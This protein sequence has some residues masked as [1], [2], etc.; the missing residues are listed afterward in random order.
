MKKLSILIT[1]LLITLTASAQ[2]SNSSQIPE[3]SKDTKLIIIDEDNSVLTDSEFNDKLGKVSDL[4]GG[5]VVIVETYCQVYDGFLVDL[6]KKSPFGENCIILSIDNFDN[7]YYITST[8]DISNLEEDID[9]SFAATLKSFGSSYSGEQMFQAFIDAVEEN[10]SLNPTSETTTE[11]RISAAVDLPDDN[12]AKYEIGKRT[13]QNPLVFKSFL[14]DKLTQTQMQLA[15]ETPYVDTAVKVYD[16]AGLL[17]D[18]EISKLQNRIHQFV[19]KYNVDMVVVTINH[20]NKTNMNGELP[21]DNFAMDFYEYNDFGKGVQAKEGYD[22]VILLIDMQYRKFRILDV[23]VPNDKW[24][25]ARYNVDKYVENMAPDLTA[26]NYY[27]AINYFIGAYESDYEYEISF[28]W[29]KCSLFALILGFI[30]L[31]VEKRKYKNIRK[32]T[33]A[34]NYVKEGS[35]R[36]TVN[37]DTFVSTHTTKTY[38]PPQKS[39]G[40]GGSHGGSS[41]RSFGGGGGSF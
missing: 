9:A 34:A 29:I 26:Q 31:S 19:N 14:K 17:N 11:S 7:T 3:V 15:L 8:G 25:V 12:W 28:P 39:S 35:F 36:L 33:S 30:L 37:K 16:A 1:A 40:G 21:S 4:I 41:G 27:N 5:D 20:N 2:I 24:G 32:A 22:G 6:Y 23:G 38:D 13:E 18:S 10:Y